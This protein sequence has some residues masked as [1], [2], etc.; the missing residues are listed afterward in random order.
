MEEELDSVT[1]IGPKTIS[2]NQV[3]LETE[4]SEP[5]WHSGP[6]STQNQVFLENYLDDLRRVK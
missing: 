6:D 3:K 5:I 4:T 2:K 1:E